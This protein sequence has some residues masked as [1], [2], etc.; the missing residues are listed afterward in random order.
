MKKTI[1]SLIAALLLC[2]MCMGFVACNQVGTISLYD[3]A[4]ETEFSFGRFEEGVVFGLGNR[5]NYDLHYE[6][7][8]SASSTASA[9]SP[10]Y[11]N[12]KVLLIEDDTYGRET[13]NIL[14]QLYDVLIDRYID[15]KK[16]LE[17]RKTVLKEQRI[18]DY[19]ERKR[20]AFSMRPYS[21]DSYLMQRIQQ[22]GV[23]EHLYNEEN[24]IVVGKCENAD[25]LVVNVVQFNDNGRWG[26]NNSRFFQ[27]CT[28]NL[29]TYVY[30]RLCTSFTEIMSQLEIIWYWNY[31]EDILEEIPAE[32]YLS[33]IA[34]DAILWILNNAKT[35]DLYVM[36][37][38]YFKA[39]E[40]VAVAWL[41]DP[42]GQ[43]YLN[44][45][46]NRR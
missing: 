22:V 42:R 45:Y 9:P 41:N 11:Q 44:K 37:K 26:I 19:I 30:D 21:T 25:Y 46:Y 3:F 7:D 27:H 35:E 8:S 29:Y 33:K 28:L 17:K 12:T 6:D 20:M 32:A 15:S 40:E 43:A 31:S 24:A 36:G 16:L 4:K 5:E 10:Y 13:I 39:M 1:L 18:E 14:Q 2:T 38:G 34:P 23:G